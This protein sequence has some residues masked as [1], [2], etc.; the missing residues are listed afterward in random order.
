MFVIPVGQGR[1]AVNIKQKLQPRLF[2]V[3]G[4]KDHV[5][6]NIRDEFGK[7]QTLP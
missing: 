3:A 4:A 6:V 2:D 1:I 7:I 5:G